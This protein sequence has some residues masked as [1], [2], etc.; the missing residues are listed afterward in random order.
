[1]WGVDRHANPLLAAA[2]EKDNTIKAR[3]DN[4]AIAI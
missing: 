1:L 3:Q 2:V 4:G